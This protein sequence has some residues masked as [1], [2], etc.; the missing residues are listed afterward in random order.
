MYTCSTHPV[1]LQA[2]TDGDITTVFHSFF[3]LKLLPDGSDAEVERRIPDGRARIDDLEI[4]LRMT[5]LGCVKDLDNEN[6]S[7]F[8]VSTS[9]GSRYY[10]TWR[11]FKWR[12]FVAVSTGCVLHAQFS[13]MCVNLCLF[14]FTGFK[15]TDDF[16]YARNFHITSTGKS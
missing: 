11:G 10:C 9:D 6:C 8:V 14:M 7:S 3:F 4:G 1:I 12:V 2:R 5:V 15:I 16:I 13:I